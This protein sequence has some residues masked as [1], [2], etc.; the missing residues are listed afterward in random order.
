MVRVQ[1]VLDRLVLSVKLFFSSKALLTICDL[2]QKQLVAI[3]K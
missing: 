1:T 3:V 2:V